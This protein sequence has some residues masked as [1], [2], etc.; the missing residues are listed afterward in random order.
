M[1]DRSNDPSHHERMLLPQSYMSLPQICV[2]VWGGGG[3]KGGANISNQGSQILLAQGPLKASILALLM[4][5][6]KY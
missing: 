2:C 1:K 6:N 5:L 3:G 4:S